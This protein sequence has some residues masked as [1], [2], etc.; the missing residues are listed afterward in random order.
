MT[1]L[2]IVTIGIIVWF[3]MIASL[4]RRQYRR[5]RDEIR[6]HDRERTRLE[7]CPTIPEDRAGAIAPSGTFH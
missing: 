1:T 5:Y 6:R 3:V 2:V 7:D 4:V